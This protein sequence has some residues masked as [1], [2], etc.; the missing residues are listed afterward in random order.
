MNS[1]IE[2][3]FVAILRMFDHKLNLLELLHEKPA[4]ATIRL[5][6][7]GFFTGSPQTLDHSK[8]LGMRPNDQGSAVKSL[9]VH[10]RHTSNGYILSIKNTGDHYNQLISQSWL[11]VFGSVDSDID[12]PTLFTLVDHQGK[13]V[14]LKDLSSTH[15]PISLMTEDGDYLGG[16][17]VNGSPYVYLAKTE[18]RFKT[19][20]VLS[21][22]ERKVPHT[23]D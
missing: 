7:G 16:L 23:P 10:F 17:K 9:K 8:L 21:I 4:L 19:T 13:A 11:E 14:T 2:K 3:S 6:S 15:S 12:D 5:F 22:L 1:D 18:A 20:F